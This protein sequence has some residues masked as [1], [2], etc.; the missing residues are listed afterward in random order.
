M[1]KIIEEY[2]DKLAP[3]YDK[4]TKG[5]FEWIASLKVRKKLLPFVEKE[6]V[7]LDLAC[8]TGQ[9]AEPFIKKGCKVIGIDI[10]SEMLKIARK[11]YKFQKLYQYD[12]EDGFKRLRFKKNLFSGIMAVGILEFLK[13]LGKIIKEVAELTKPG[14][15]VAF[16]YELLLKNYK[17][18]SK[19]VSPLGEG[20]IK[21]IP[22]LLSFKV[23]R[24]TQNEIKEILDKNKI[25]KIY[26]ERFIGYFKTKEK[27]P[28]YYQMIIGQ[29]C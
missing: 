16:T 12:L 9:S 1:K 28:I 11:K 15:Y 29:K 14:G 18:Q 27:I 7:V 3:V 4:V 20:L 21:P 6:D 17:I 25:K 24:H 26:S 8:G 13:N 10:S 22:K 19:R 5:E 2:N 23:Y